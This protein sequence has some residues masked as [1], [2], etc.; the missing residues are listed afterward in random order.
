MPTSSHTCNTPLSPHIG[1]FSFWCRQNK[2]LFH[3][4]P[5]VPSLFI[6]GK[7]RTASLAAFALCVASHIIFSVQLRSA[8]STMCVA[9]HCMNSHVSPR[10][11]AAPASLAGYA[12]SAIG[13]QKFWSPCGK[14]ERFRGFWGVVGNQLQADTFSIRPATAPCPH[15]R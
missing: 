6:V 10:W 14:E 3:V 4:E 7:P 2:D 13:H 12:A 9:S 1:T 5:R 15:A 8:D 11:D